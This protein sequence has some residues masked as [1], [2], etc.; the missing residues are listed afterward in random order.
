ME[1]KFLQDEEDR[2]CKKYNCS[3]IDE[4]LI[5]QDKILRGE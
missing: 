2:L 5:K 4:V 1:N 3:S